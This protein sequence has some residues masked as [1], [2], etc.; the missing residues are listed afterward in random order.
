MEEGSITY[1]VWLSAYTKKLEIEDPL[2]L[3]IIAV[4]PELRQYAPCSVSDSQWL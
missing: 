2:H 4:T 3:Q 1:G